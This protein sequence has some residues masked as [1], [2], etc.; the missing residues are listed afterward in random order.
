MKLKV[1]DL[2]GPIRSSSAWHKNSTGSI[3]WYATFES[4]STLWRIVSDVISLYLCTMLIFQRGHLP[5]WDTF[6]TNRLSLSYRYGYLLSFFFGG[7]NRAKL[8]EI[9]RNMFL[10]HL[11]PFQ[12]V[13]KYLPI[14]TH[15]DA[16]SS[17][18]CVWKRWFLRGDF[19]FTAFRTCSKSPMFVS[20]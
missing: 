19:R 11:Q 9:S 8:F 2:G 16:Q 15:Q 7:L 17:L 18:W 4:V 13:R 5:D 12:P 20:R 14:Q 6:L 10:R 3:L 1:I